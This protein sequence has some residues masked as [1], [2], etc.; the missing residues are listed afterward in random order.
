LTDPTVGPGEPEPIRDPGA[1]NPSLAEIIPTL[2]HSL[3]VL[4]S[5]KLQLLEREFSS[6]IVK[7]RAAA[8]FLAAAALLAVLGLGL[9]GAGA[10]LL[11]G[12]W[13]DSPGGGLL[14]VA[15][16]YLAAA[17]A[18]LGIARS[19]LRKMNGFLRTTLE[20]LKRDVEW[21]KNLP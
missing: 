2:L 1:G 4:L 16:V 5:A 12:R 6:D 3:A 17:L 15:A 20:D 9:A 14:I 18:A 11:L 7:V 10:A 8:V 21:L 13:L 19:R